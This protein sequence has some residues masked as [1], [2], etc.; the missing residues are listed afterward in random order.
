MKKTHKTQI[1]LDGLSENQII[2]K[3]L[4]CRNEDW[5]SFVQ[6]FIE[7][8]D[9]EFKVLRNELLLKRKNWLSRDIFEEYKS[10]N[11]IYT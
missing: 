9:S 8:N 10:E 7:M 4:I 5:C 1:Y 3:S 11:I 2:N 6:K